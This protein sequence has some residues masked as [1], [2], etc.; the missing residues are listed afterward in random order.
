MNFRDISFKEWSAWIMLGGCLSAGLFYF[1]LLY[2]HRQ[3]TG[4]WMVPVVPFIVIT[5]ILIAVAM[6]GHSVAAMFNPSEAMQP[7][8]E[9]DSFIRLKAS[10]ISGTILGLGVIISLL[11]NAVTP[12]GNILFHMIFGNLLFAQ[13]AE[14]ALQVVSYRRAHLAGDIA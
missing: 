4:T 9:R 7:A 1:G 10:H 12:N 13:I 14:Y 2:S 6:I 5:I 3:A 8:D 11:L